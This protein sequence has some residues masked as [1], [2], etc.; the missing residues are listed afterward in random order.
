MSDE[1]TTAIE[2]LQNVD[3]NKCRAEIVA[4]MRDTNLRAHEGVP[5]GS[6]DGTREHFTDHCSLLALA[7]KVNGHE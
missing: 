3:L 1:I 6:C 2:R 5:C 4:M 7:R